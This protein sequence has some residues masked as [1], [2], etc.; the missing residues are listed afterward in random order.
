MIQWTDQERNQIVETYITSFPNE[1]PIDKKVRDIANTLLPP[2]RQ[3]THISPNDPVKREICHRQRIQWTPPV[4][5]MRG[6]RQSKPQRQ[7]KSRR[8]P[9]NSEHAV[10]VARSVKTQRFVAT[11]QLSKDLEDT[12]RRAIAVILAATQILAELDQIIHGI[13]Q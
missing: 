2:D 3:R 11:S 8:I 5:S 6:Y 4:S 10:D 12:R 13:N 1:I 9:M 7:R